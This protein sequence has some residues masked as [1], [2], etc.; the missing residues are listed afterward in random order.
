MLRSG[1]S[2]T[3]SSPRPR[4]P[5]AVPAPCAEAVDTTCAPGAEGYGLLRDGAM[6]EY[7]IAEPRVLHRIPESVS[8]EHAAMTE[9]FAVAYNAVVER[10][11]VL[12]GTLVVIQG[13]GT[14]GLL[15]LQVAL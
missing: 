12:P 3:V 13:A 14:I 15:A 7:L 10:A 5:S 6:A 11:N 2:A 9:P 1:A 8:F 4:H